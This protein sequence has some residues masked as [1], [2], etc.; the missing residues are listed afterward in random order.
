MKPD[1]I[2]AWIESHPKWELAEEIGR[3]FKADYVIEI[4]ISDFSLFEGT[5]TT[6]YRGKTEADVSVTEM[7]EGSGE[8]IFSKELDFPTRSASRATARSS[9]WFHLSET[10]SRG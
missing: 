8:R 9:R 2:R 1:Y 4:E 5:S 10:T 3:E 7:T 6:L